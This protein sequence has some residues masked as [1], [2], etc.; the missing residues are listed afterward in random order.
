MKLNLKAL[1]AAIAVLIWFMLFAVSFYMP[2]PHMFMMT[3]VVPLGLGLCYAT[4][5]AVDE[6]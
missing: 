3:L 2:T 6:W 5:K 4:Y 1:A